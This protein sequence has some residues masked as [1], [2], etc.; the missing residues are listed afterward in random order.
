[1]DKWNLDIYTTGK[2]AQIIGL[3]LTQEQVNGLVAEAKKQ[4]DKM[5]EDPNTELI[6][7]KLRTLF[8]GY[9]KEGAGG[10][11]KID[12]MP[13]AEKMQS[14]DWWKLWREVISSVYGVTPIFVGV[15][16]SGKTGNNPRMEVDVQNDTTEMYQQII[17]VPFNTFIVPKLGVSDWI[18]VFP[19]LEGKDEMQAITVLQAKVRTVIE[20]SN[21]GLKAEIT[22]D[23]EVRISGAPTPPEEQSAE[24]AL[25]RPAA[26]P[27]GGKHPFKVQEVFSPETKGENEK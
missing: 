6:T 9:G 8:I 10:M 12:S 11:Q 14:L 4:R 22:D 23:G 17:E 25:A 18:G 7:N 21:A 1:M 26:P 27:S 16:E 13:P 20:A 3:P 5:E 19:E 24:R 15:V 2:I